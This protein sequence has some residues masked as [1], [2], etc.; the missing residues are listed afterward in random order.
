VSGSA[1][2]VAT[3]V[4]VWTLVLLPSPS[5]PLVAFTEKPTT[6]PSATPPA[7]ELV[8]HLRGYPTS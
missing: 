5:F 1:T 3:L 7:I 8:S 6:K 4:L 2:D